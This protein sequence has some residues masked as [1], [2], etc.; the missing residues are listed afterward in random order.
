MNTPKDDFYRQHLD[1]TEPEFR[2]LL[3]EGKTELRRIITPQPG[4]VD[5]RGMIY[6]WLD[7]GSFEALCP[8]R[9]EYSVAGL[10]VKVS[11]VK[12]EKHQS[13]WVFVWVVGLKIA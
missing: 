13:A 5:L 10:A 9:G 12:V 4:R 6:E 7:A 11:G 8:W 2:E 3:D 1:L